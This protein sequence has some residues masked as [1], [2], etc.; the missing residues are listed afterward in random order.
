LL[1]KNKLNNFEI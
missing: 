1:P